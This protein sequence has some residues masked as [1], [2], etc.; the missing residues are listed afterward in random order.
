MPQAAVIDLI[1][2]KQMIESPMYDEIMEEGRIETRREDIGKV[3]ATRFG[4]EVSAEFTEMLNGIANLKQLSR[5]FDIALTG[6]VAEFRK[7]VTK[8][9]PKKSSR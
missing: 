2:R 5:L 8:P 1:G 3:L 6:Q 9:K 4:D 7:A